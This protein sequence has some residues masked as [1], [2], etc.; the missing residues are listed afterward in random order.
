[1][2]VQ[3]SLLSG[4]GR[5]PGFPLPAPGTLQPPGPPAR[6]EALGREAGKGRAGAYHVLHAKKKGNSG[7]GM[8]CLEPF[9]VLIRK[10]GTL[11]TAAAL[12]GWVK[13]SFDHSRLSEVQ[14]GAPGQLLALLLCRT[15]S[16]PRPR[17]G[18]TG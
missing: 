4:S 5:W 10:C 8:D 11:G 16:W 3:L 14:G 6:A 9:L 7:T 1:M 12:Q 18:D 15:P 17:D 13:S 2:A